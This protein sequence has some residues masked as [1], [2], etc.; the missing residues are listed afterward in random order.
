M[1][2]RSDLYEKAAN[3]RQMVAIDR[4]PPAAWT[5]RLREGQ[6]NPALEEAS[7]RAVTTLDF[8]PREVTLTYK[9]AFKRNSRAGLG[10][11]RV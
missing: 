8:G 4:V 11:A 7:G 2:Y 6:V 9:L 5:R 1:Q 10:T 3:I